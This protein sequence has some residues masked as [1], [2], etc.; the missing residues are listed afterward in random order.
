MGGYGADLPEDG[1]AS[2]MITFPNL[3]VLYKKLSLKMEVT[4]NWHCFITYFF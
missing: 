3:L 2:S 4:V 1:S